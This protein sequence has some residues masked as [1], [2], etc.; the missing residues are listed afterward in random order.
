MKKLLLLILSLS[1]SLIIVAQES[2]IK[3]FAE[4][5]RTTRWMNPLCF[6][7]STLRMVNITQD[8]NFNELVNDIEK[9]LIYTLDSATVA[10]K[11]YKS[12]LKEYE[13]IGYEEYIT[14]YGTQ[15][16]RILGKDQEY[17]GVLA[18]EGRAAAFYLR[19]EIPF[20]KIP[21]LI[22]SFQSDD[23]LPLITEQFK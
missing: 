4:P 23:M 22:Q 6:Y 13:A 20:A 17:V 12:W 19:G 18:A 1:F 11:D 5:R 10:S 3:E 15:E 14:I 16:I 21:E 8:P 7:P 2:I 9:V